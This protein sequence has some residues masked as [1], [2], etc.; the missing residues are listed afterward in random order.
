M[1]MET[2]I[3][4]TSDLGLATYL[5]ASGINLLRIDRGDTRRAFFVFDSPDPDLLSCW[6]QG[7]AVINALAFYNAY[8]DLKARLFRSGSQ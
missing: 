6:Q 3:Y 5:F 8:Q 4:Q 1:V 2:Q 7:K